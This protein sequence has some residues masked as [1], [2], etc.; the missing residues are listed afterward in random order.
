MWRRSMLLLAAGAIAGGC[1]RDAPLVG[2][3]RE[4]TEV[5]VALPSALAA[6]SKDHPVED[7]ISDA[8]Q[9]LL[10]AVGDYGIP[11]RA[12]LLAFQTRPSDPSAWDALQRA[13]EAIARTLP[14]E[15]RPDLDALRLELD[16]V[17]PR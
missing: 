6:K 14:E 10:P 9:R 17:A 16:T 8:L 5:T 1:M 7:A 3:D 2:P 11:L 15:N 4:S 12:P 13:L